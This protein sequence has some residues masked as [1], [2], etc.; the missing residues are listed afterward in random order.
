MDPDPPILAE[1]L[2]PYP[3]SVK[4]VAYASRAILY[5]TFAPVTEIFWDATQAVCLGFTYTNHERDNFINLAVYANHVT[6][7]FPYGAQLKDPEGRLKGAGTRVRHI[8][9]A[10]ADDLED[11]YISGLVEQSY[12]LAIIP[13]DPLPETIIV[14]SMKGPK[15]RPRPEN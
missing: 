2:A 15:R 8:R 11:A 14:K 7:I 4:E 9:L 10:G 12:R 13:K 1:F 6:L 3:D 5:A